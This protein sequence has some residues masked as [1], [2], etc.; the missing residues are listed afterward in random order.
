MIRQ[1]RATRLHIRDLNAGYRVKH[2]P[3]S[4]ITLRLTR[5]NNTAETA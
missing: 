4:W 3:D 5:I 2:R 1:L